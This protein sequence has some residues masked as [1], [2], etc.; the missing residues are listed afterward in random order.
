M[1]PL[2]YK[3]AQLTRMEDKRARHYPHIGQSIPQLSVCAI[4]GLGYGGNGTVY[5]VEECPTKAHDIPPRQYAMKFISMKV[6]GF[7]F[8]DAYK[9]EY[10]YHTRI[11]PHP[12]I[13]R[14]YAMMET[15]D[16]LFLLFEYIGGADFH[17]FLK[18]FGRFISRDNLLI[19]ALFLQILDAVAHVHDQGI[20]H[21]D[22]K[23]ENI[24]CN[25]VHD[26]SRLMLTDFGASTDRPRICHSDGYVRGT[27]S[28]SPPGKPNHFI[29]IYSKVLNPRTPF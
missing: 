26:C 17:Q 29:S 15:Q 7:K 2:C 4:A 6:H 8:V 24:L 1:S 21:N 11:P 14:A 27:H 20:Y 22:L 10:N 25:H 3:H 5:L 12:N 9:K 18:N 13:V 23:P 16:S 28:Y 19:K